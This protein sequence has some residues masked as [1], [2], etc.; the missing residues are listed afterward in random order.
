VRFTGVVLH[1]DLP[2]GFVL[3]GDPA[4]GARPLSLA[5][6]AA[7]KRGR[8]LGWTNSG[9]GGG[10]GGVGP[11][12]TVHKT[13]RNRYATTRAGSSGSYSNIS[14]NSGSSGSS[15]LHTAKK[16]KLVYTGGKKKKKK[17]EAPSS[18]GGRLSGGGGGLGGGGVGGAT[19]A[20][21]ST[22]TAATP[23]PGILQR[24]KAAAAATAMAIANGGSINTGGGGILRTPRTTVPTTTIGRKVPPQPPLGPGAAALEVLRLQRSRGVTQ[25]VAVDVAAMMPLQSVGWK[26]GDTVVIFGEVRAMMAA[27]A[28]D[29][30]DAPP[31]AR[32]RTRTR[33][34]D[35]ASEE[36][37]G[38]EMEHSPSTEEAQSALQ[39]V[40]AVLKTNGRGVVARIIRNVNGTDVNLLTKA[41]RLRRAY[42]RERCGWSGAAVADGTT[43]VGAS[44]SLALG[45]PGIGVEALIGIAKT[46][47]DKA[48]E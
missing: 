43:S 17:K 8:G 46:P 37:S 18:I 5:A 38:G 45:M 2:G 33:T 3:V 7:A 36:A 10:S 44:A 40:L 11:P 15:L 39:R 20:A 25:I 6:A 29:P 13:P 41:L 22:S 34:E 35:L 21:S 16:R 4:A 32:T 27:D 28:A 9:A 42:V 19:T 14:S 12:S 31:D 30:A 24:Q 48:N 1:V 26:V 23:R 47:T